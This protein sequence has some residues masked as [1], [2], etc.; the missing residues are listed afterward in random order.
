MI[1]SRCL[2]V[3]RRPAGLTRSQTSWGGEGGY[4]NGRAG[5]DQKAGAASPCWTKSILREDCPDSPA[6]RQSHS[7]WAFSRKLLQSWPGLVRVSSN[8]I[9]SPLYITPHHTTPP[10]HHITIRTPHHN[11]W[12]HLTWHN[13]TWHV[14]QSQWEEVV[15]SNIVKAGVDVKLFVN[16]R[17]KS[18][19]SLQQKTVINK[20]TMWTANTKF[21]IS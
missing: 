18:W 3:Y 20:A 14:T 10:L 9:T 7:V 16:S 21:I 17:V 13:D 19:T 11:K 12:P 5:I 4:L 15:V 2:T 6:R 1:C 8:H